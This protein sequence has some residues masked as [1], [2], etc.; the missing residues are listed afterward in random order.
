MYLLLMLGVLSFILCWLT[1]YIYKYKKDI[2]EN[3]DIVLV[4]PTAILTVFFIIGS[5]LAVICQCITTDPD[6]EKVLDSRHKI[7]AEINSTDPAMHNMGIDDAVVYNRK[8]KAGKASLDNKWI[9]LF[10]CKQWADAEFIDVDTDSYVII[11]KTEV[12]E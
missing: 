3:W 12:N 5:L 2:W 9:N 11:E 6:V 7:I 8:V 10:V 1:I 4:I